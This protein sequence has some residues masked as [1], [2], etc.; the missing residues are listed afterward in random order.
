LYLAGEHVLR[1]VKAAGAPN[2]EAF[3]QSKAARQFATAGRI[4]QTDVLD[5]R[6]MAELPLEEGVLSEAVKVL[7]HERVPF[8]SFPYEWPPE[9][10]HAAG[11]LTLDLAEAL[12]AEG[13]GLKDGT[14][15]N[16]LFR[17][18]NPVFVDVL[19]LEKR[20]PGD[21]V[22]L[23][24]AQFVRT[25]ILPLA[26]NRHFGVPLDQMLLARRDGLEPEEVRRMCGP[27][28]QF[29]PP[30]LTMVTLPSLLASRQEADDP[31]MY[32]KRPPTEPEKA[33]FILQSLF[34]GLRR[35]L[36]RVAPRPGKH[37]TWSDYTTLTSYSR[38]QAAGKQAFVQAV[39]TE[40]RPV[41]VLDVGCNTGVF[42][43]MAARNGASVVAVDYDPV[44]VGEV[45]RNARQ[46]KLDILPLVVNLSRP[47][48]GT[49]WRNQEGAPFLERARGRFDAVLMLAV[50]HHLLV[51]ERIPLDDVLDLAAELTT[52]L[53]I[54][55]FV[56]PEDPMFR[57]IARGREGLHRGLDVNAFEESCRRR[58]H[59]MRAEQIE[60]SHR[61][62]YLLRRRQ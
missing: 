3:L 62:L 1:V 20:D 55:E 57:R 6:Q 40:H 22:W 23:A 50:L 45:W 28:Q 29:L 34:R 52:E 26:V 31:R 58:F 16:I 10:L 19:S 8:A 35:A 61:W 37:S 24:Y 53:L 56:A 27:L 11:E 39:L 44:V 36:R 30:F 25:F 13:I 7:S 4:V 14:P 21:P 48:P 47:T 33:K 41:R 51:S 60:G 12:L 9:M 5:A 49:G 59:V 15:Y 43:M 38:S 42:S 17:G 32:Q 46:A 18:P 2:L 54:I